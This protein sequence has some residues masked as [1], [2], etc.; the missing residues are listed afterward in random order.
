MNLEPRI[1]GKRLT[2]QP[3]L[4]IARMTTP[5]P[6]MGGSPEYGEIKS[7][8]RSPGGRPFISVH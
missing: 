3:P 1:A 8:G 2:D 5:P 6:S 7:S 4:F